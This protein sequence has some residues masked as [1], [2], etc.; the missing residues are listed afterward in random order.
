[1]NF[2]AL[3]LAHDI[4]AGQKDVSIARQEYG[5]Q[6]LAFMKTQHND[7]PYTQGFKFKVGY[8]AAGDPDTSIIGVSDEIGVFTERIRKDAPEE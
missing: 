7:A 2:L 4:I 1:M 5:R 3:N 8:A 6:C